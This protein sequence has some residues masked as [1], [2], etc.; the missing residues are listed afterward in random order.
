MLN[1]ESDTGSG[2]G[3]H[4]N[5]NNLLTGLGVNKLTKLIVGVKFIFPVGVSHGS[6]AM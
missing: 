5:D 2:T 1:K 6:P 3:D 4:D